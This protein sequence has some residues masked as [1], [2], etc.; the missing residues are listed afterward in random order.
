LTALTARAPI[1]TWTRAAWLTAGLGSAA[2]AR[3]AFNGT[4][5]AGG[6]A[7]GAAFGVTILILAVVAGWRSGRPRASSVAVGVGG[8]LVLVAVPLLLGPTSRATVGIRP[9]PFLVW[10][11]V[12]ALVA[13]AEEAMLRGALLSALDD[14]G[15]P[16]L[17]VIGSSVAF[18]VMHVPL[19]GWG[20]VPIDLGAG[21][22]L[23]GL[24]YVSGGTLAPTVAHLLADL[25][26]WWL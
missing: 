18:A 10:A 15:G 1:A 3:S 26:T 14:A 6:F 12:T 8:G 23:A 17:A 25:A 7:S 11:L 19:Y 4:G 2:V 13:T 22:L 21:V 16:I 9:E 24:R 5:A 20:V